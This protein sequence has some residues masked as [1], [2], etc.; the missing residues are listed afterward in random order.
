M[1]T[2]T[3]IYPTLQAQS[4]STLSE[5]RDCSTKESIYLMIKLI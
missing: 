4:K 5:H 3:P 1:Q 2:Q